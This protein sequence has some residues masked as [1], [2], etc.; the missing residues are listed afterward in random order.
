MGSVIGWMIEV[1]WRRFVSS[2]KWVNPG[3]LNGPYLPIYGFSICTL[4]ALSFLSVSFVR[5]ELYQKLVLFILMALAITLMEFFAGLIFIKGMKI[6][7]WDYSD[8]RFN[9]MGI[10]CLPYSIC[11]VILRAIYYL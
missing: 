8:N 4:F 11:W 3:F 5:D 9:F 2:H 7:L 1:V 6:R 10:I